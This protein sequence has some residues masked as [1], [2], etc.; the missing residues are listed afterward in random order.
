MARSGLLASETR[1]RYNRHGGQKAR[2]EFS[3]KTMNMAARL[4][5]GAA[6]AAVLAG[7]PLTVQAADPAAQLREAVTAYNIGKYKKTLELAHPLAQNGDTQAQVLIGR[8]Y[9]NGLGVPQD[10]ETA[11]KWY[12]LAAE[13]GNAEAQ[14]LIAYACE[15]GVGVPRD[16][17]AAVRWIELAAN[18]G[19]P[20]AEFALSQRYIKGDVLP[21]DHKLSFQWALKAARQGNPQA[22]RYVAACYEFGVGVAEDAAAADK[23]YAKAAAQGLERDGNIFTRTLKERQ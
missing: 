21:K 23:W 12:Q 13:N 8:C 22:Q 1:A 7:A 10:F 9:E 2:K 11:A 4:A 16:P 17:Q 18:N 19:N 14:M 6:L 5:V 3:M 15:A 20:E